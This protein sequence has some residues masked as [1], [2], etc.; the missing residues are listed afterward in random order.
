M[1][2]DADDISLELIEALGFAVLRQQNLDALDISIAVIETPPGLSVRDAIRRL[3]QSDPGAL[4]EF[5]HLYQAMPAG[6]KYPLAADAHKPT[7]AS[8][9][10]I[11][12]A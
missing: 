7:T 12:S 1:P 9:I 5:N 3:R 2:A 10:G 6:D 8:A 11:S 4:Y